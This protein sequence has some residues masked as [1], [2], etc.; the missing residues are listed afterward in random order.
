MEFDSVPMSKATV[1]DYLASNEDLILSFNADSVSAGDE[2]DPDWGN[3]T[4]SFGATD[5]RLI[6]LDGNGGFKDIEYSHISSIETESKRDG[7][8]GALLVGC[9]AG[10]LGLAGMG[11]LSDDPGTGLLLVSIGIGG[12]VLAKHMFDNHE[13]TEKQEVKVITGDE[14]HQQ[15]TFTTSEN[16]GAELSSIVREQG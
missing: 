15:L 10:F 1:K 7:P 14:A 5:R 2:N 4:Y 13:E 3:S 8:D 9:C 6:Y 12:L 11:A 16:V